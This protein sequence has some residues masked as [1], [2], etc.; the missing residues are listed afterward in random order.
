MSISKFPLEN[1]VALVTGVSRLRGIGFA[2]ARRLASMGADLFIHSYATYDSILPLER[3]PNEQ[4]QIITRLKESGRRVEHMDIDFADAEAPSR[5]VHNAVARFGHIEIL[6]ANH[7]Y[8]APQRLSQLTVAE[9]DRHLIVNVRATL[10]LV[11]EFAAQHDGRTGGRILLMTSG[12]HRDPMGPMLSYGA[13]KG[14]IHQITFTLSDE[15]IGQGITVNAVNPSPT[16]TGWA[17]PEVYQQV[18]RHMH[19]GSRQ[20]DDAARL[21]AWLTTDDARW[22]TGQ[23][24]DSEGGYRRLPW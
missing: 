2:V 20:P 19:W 24:I 7:A 18:L 8:S 1:R 21:M 9:I 11:S 15:L 10:L 6:I 13:S 22:I 5:V 12:Q 16:D 3:Q 4:E 14:A 23:V 17:K